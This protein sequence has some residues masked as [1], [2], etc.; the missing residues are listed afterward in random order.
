MSCE[1]GLICVRF[2]AGLLA[3]SGSNGDAHVDA[4]EDALV[5]QVS[6]GNVGQTK[7]RHGCDF[8]DASQRAV[9]KESSSERDAISRFGAQTKCTRLRKGG[10]TQ[11]AHSARQRSARG[12][13]LEELQHCV[14]KCEDD[15]ALPF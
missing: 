1:G 8:L 13:P 6:I 9:R 10:V 4:N 3:L 2:E 14:R 12:S 11:V 5:L 15:V 7:L